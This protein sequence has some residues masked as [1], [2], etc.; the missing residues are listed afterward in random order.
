MV[1]EQVTQWDFPNNAPALIF[2]VPL[3]KTTLTSV[4]V[5]VQAMDFENFGLWC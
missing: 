1:R 5:S 4:N 2:E 3:T